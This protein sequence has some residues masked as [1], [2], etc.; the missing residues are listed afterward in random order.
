[1]SGLRGVIGDPLSRSVVAMPSRETVLRFEGGPLDGEE[2]RKTR[3]ARLPIFLTASGDPLRVALGHRITSAAH[4]FVS[5]PQSGP[6]SCYSLKSD[7][8]ADARRIATYAYI[9][10]ERTAS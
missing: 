10:T 4:G 7:V 3:P 2:R 8:T 6:T 5:T 9:T 1:M